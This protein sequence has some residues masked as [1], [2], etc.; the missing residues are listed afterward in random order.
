MVLQLLLVGAG[1]ICQLHI[2]DP[3]RVLELAYFPIE[4]VLLDLGRALLPLL[5]YVQQVLILYLQLLHLSTEIAVPL[6]ELPVPVAL[7]Y[8]V[9]AGVVPFDHFNDF[10]QL[11]DGFLLRLEQLD[12]V[13]LHR[14]RPVHFVDPADV[15]GVEIL[16]SRFGYNLYSGV[17]D[18]G[19]RLRPS[20]PALVR[21]GLGLLGLVGDVGRVPGWCASSE[22]PLPPLP[23]LLARAG[24][25]LPLH[26]LKLLDLLNF[27]TF[28]RDNDVGCLFIRGRR[29]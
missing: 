17:P 3:E 7:I 2:F 12:V 27:R 23:G 22:R 29:F 16:G 1:D 25:I 10:L 24:S 6:S 21:G 15:P 5:D 28:G 13:K 9:R 8:F 14:I 19:P 18:P 11:L 20:M 4:D 26:K